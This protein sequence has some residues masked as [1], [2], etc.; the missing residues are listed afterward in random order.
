M[1]LLISLLLISPDGIQI[2]S[3][4]LNALRDNSFSTYPILVI[5]A[6][7]SVPHRLIPV[8]VCTSI[9][10]PCLRL[11]CDPRQYYNAAECIALLAASDSADSWNSSCRF[12]SAVLV[13]AL[14][15][16]GIWSESCPAVVSEN[17]DAAVRLS[18]PEKAIACERLFRGTCAA[19][20]QVT[21][22]YAVPFR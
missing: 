17:I 13:K 1:S 21:D 19:L 18:G 22:D 3:A 14:S 20:A 16:L 10:A 9:R 11:L 8:S 4:A 15:M 5:R 6:L 2:V 7:L 12:H